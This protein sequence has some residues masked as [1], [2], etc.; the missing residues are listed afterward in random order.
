[1]WLLGGGGSEMRTELWPEF[2][3]GRQ[4]LE[5]VRSR[6]QKFPA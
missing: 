4:D 2:L 1:M 6:V 5:D 3:S